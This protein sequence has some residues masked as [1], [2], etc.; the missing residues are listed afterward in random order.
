MTPPRRSHWW[1]FR[2]FFVLLPNNVSMKVYDS[3]PSCQVHMG[4][5]PQLKQSA[6]PSVTPLWTPSFSWV[7]PPTSQQLHSFAPLS[8]THIPNQQLHLPPSLPSH[9]TYP[10]TNSTNTPLYA[11]STYLLTNSST[12]LSVLAKQRY[13]H[14]KQVRYAWL[15]SMTP[16]SGANPST[17]LSRVPAR[18]VRTWQ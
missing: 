11:P 3:K 15:T 1:C 13:V 10:L 5:S 9:P 2:V 18:R 14:R 8:R 6:A 4:I 12:T 17:N 16:G 7:L